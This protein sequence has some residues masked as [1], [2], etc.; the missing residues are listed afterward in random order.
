MD[1]FADMVRDVPGFLSKA[2]L[3]NGASRGGF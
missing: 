3:H 2:W 1:R